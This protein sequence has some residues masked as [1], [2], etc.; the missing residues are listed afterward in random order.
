MMGSMWWQ[1]LAIGAAMAGA[2]VYLIRRHLA[3]RRREACSACPLMKL[4]NN[5]PGEPDRPEDRH[6]G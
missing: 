4:A 1:Y 3:R 2:I 5:R 6:A